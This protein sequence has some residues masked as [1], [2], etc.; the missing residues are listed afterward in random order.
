MEAKKMSSSK[1]K[2]KSHRHS[3]V[4]ENILDIEPSKKE[5]PRPSGR[6]FSELPDPA[7]IME[8]VAA[9]VKELKAEMKES[10]KEL[11]KAEENLEKGKDEALEIKA[12]VQS[13]KLKGNELM[14]LSFLLRLGYDE[15]VIKNHIERENEILEK[16]VKKKE[17]QVKKAEADVERMIKVNQ[18]GERA[19][20][21]AQT[22]Y[23]N[24]VVTNQKRRSQL[25]QVDLDL[26]AQESQV[27]HRQSMRKV[28]TE[29]KDMFKK[30]LQGIL[31]M[32][33]KR[34]NDKELV[35]KVLKI[36]GK[37]MAHDLGIEEN[38]SDDSDSSSS[39]S[40]SNSDESSVDDDISISSASSDSGGD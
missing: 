20:L 22:A 35:L 32:I 9:E 16:K 28:D 34:S 33:K 17:K 18:E 7:E 12:K 37:V 8:R 24:L 30:A 4:E 3:V 31:Q 21:N 15:E 25:D 39:S 38:F 10:F 26:Y 11:M 36:S 2:R 14:K 23:N 27:K 40:S 6:N 5:C 1:I 19:I 13:S 29:S